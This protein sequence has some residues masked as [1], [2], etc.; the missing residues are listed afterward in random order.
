MSGELIDHVAMLVPDLEVAIAKW[1]AVLGYTFSPIARYRTTRYSDGSNP[2]PHSHDARI[3]MSR[4]GPPYIEL[5]GVTGKG[6]HGPQQLGVHH[7]GIRLTTDVAARGAE[8]AM[9]GVRIDGTSFMEDGR[10]H[11]CFT[12]KED[13]DGIRLE[14]IAPFNGPTVADDGSPLWIDPV[15]GRRSF[16]GPPPEAA[17][18]L[19][20]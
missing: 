14:F 11:L 20:S 5:M 12:A 13:M 10:V 2:A 7:I 4:E 8:C 3:C 9:L 19:G 18:I 6:T 15:T 16:W 1:S 17:E